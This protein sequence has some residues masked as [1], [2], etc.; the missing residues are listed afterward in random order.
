MHERVGIGDALRKGAGRGSRITVRAAI[1]MRGGGEIGRTDGLVV[2]VMADQILD[3]RAVNAGRG[4][5]YALKARCIR[6]L[7]A[8]TRCGQWIFI[9]RFV[10]R[11]H[12]L[13]GGVDQGDLRGKQIAE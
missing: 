1:S 7:A 13:H 8:A 11:R 9:V 10:A 4:A 5:E 2:R 12:R 6:A 3:A